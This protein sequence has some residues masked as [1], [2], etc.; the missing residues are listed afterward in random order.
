MMG[1]FVMRKSKPPPQ[2]TGWVP[3]KSSRQIRGGRRVDVALGRL[4][5]RGFTATPSV[6]FTRPLGNKDGGRWRVFEHK[7]VEWTLCPRMSLLIGSAL[8][9]V[10]TVL[11]QLQPVI[12]SS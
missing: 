2:A 11:P 3:Q 8:H 9:P 12:V 7:S 10:L 5:E 1:F 4:A 6:V